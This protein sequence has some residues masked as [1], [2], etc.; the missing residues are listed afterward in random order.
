[1]KF[2]NLKFDKRQT[3]VTGDPPLYLGELG[4]LE[5]GGWRLHLVHGARY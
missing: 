1:M 3:T 4:D 2:G 5:P